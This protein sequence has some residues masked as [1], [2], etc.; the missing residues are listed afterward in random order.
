MIGDFL[1]LLGACYGL[2]PGLCVS[3]RGLGEFHVRQKPL[4]GWPAWMRVTGRGHASYS[5][6]PRRGLPISS[7]FI[8]RG[9]VMLLTLLAVVVYLS[10]P[11]CGECT[12]CRKRTKRGKFLYRERLLQ[13]LGHCTYAH[14]E[15]IAYQENTVQK[16]HIRT[17]A[18]E[19]AHCIGRAQIVYMHRAL[20]TICLVIG[21]G[22]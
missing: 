12:C 4:I 21:G 1:L 8:G 7:T 9:D 14:A 2:I 20:A 15:A 22:L 6:C 10:S 5:A 13:C 17:H 16:L 18:C 3:G 11:Q 19:R